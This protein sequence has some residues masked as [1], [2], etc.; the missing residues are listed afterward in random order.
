MASIETIAYLRG[1]L[2]INR[3]MDGALARLV[4]ANGRA[5][6]AVS[7]GLEG[8]RRRFAIA[9]ELG[10]HELHPGRDAL[11]LCTRTDLQTRDLSREGEANAFAVELLLPRSLVEPFCDVKE[12]SLDEVREIADAFQVSMLA[13]A[14]RFVELSPEA[15]AVVVCKQGKVAWASASS[16]FGPAPAKGEAVQPASLAYEQTVGRPI[17]KDPEDV[18]ASAWPGCRQRGELVEHSAA[19]GPASTLTLL[20]RPVE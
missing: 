6:I 5:L 9:H 2:V 12:S 19:W 14:L 18:P 10:H 17:P 3:A 20:W 8:G 1:P 13:A 4:K 11:A 7:P 15:C 16:D